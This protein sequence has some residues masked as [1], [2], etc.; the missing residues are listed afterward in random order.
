MQQLFGGANRLYF[1]SVCW[2]W[3]GRAPRGQ[4]WGWGQK[5]VST[6][7]QAAAIARNGLLGSKMA[8]R[9]VCVLGLDSAQIK[10]RRLHV[11]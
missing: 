9:S 7:K 1:V 3:R 8:Q 2:I 4:S 5:M 10:C 11:D 6:P